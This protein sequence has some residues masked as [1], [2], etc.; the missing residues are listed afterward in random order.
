MTEQSTVDCHPAMKKSTKLLISGV[1]TM[2]TIVIAGETFDAIG[3]KFGLEQLG[4]SGLAGMI[5][6]F[7]LLSGG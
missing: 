7:K 6:S 5:G 4:L 3:V 1:L 2:I